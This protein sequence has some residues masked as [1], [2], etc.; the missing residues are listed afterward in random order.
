MCTL[1]RRGHGAP[2]V[3]LRVTA[4]WWRSQQLK[5]RVTLIEN[6]GVTEQGVARLNSGY[7]TTAGICKRGQ[8]NNTR[9]S[10]WS[11]SGGFSALTGIWFLPWAEVEVRNERVGTGQHVLRTLS[12]WEGVSRDQRDVSVVTNDAGQRDSTK[13]SSL[14]AGKH[15]V[16][17]PPE[18]QKTKTYLFLSTWHHTVASLDNWQIL[19]YLSPSLRALN[20]IARRQDSSGPTRP[21]GKAGSEMA[22]THKS[23]LCGVPYRSW[24]L[25]ARVKL[26]RISASSGVEL[27][28]ERPQNLRHELY[29][30][31]TGV[32]ET[33]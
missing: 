18:P 23:M 33:H 29:P 25:W 27:G 17:L 8:W 16:S 19:F 30:D 31:G 5:A 13:L 20:C 1:A 11:N 14:G 2:L 9:Q 7:W 22:P 21:P 4:D 32:K 24:N 26:P 28:T 15:F 3:A 6:H 10:W 12:P